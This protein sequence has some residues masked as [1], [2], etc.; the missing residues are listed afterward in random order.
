MENNDTN[1]NHGLD[2]TTPNLNKKENNM[3]TKKSKKTGAIIA[4]SIVAVIGVAGLI[5]GGVYLANKDKN[6]N[7]PTTVVSSNETT[8]TS[9]GTA[10]VDGKNKI[11]KGGTYTFTGSTSNG[12]IE[13]ETTEPVT[14]VLDN[15]SITN[16]EGEAIKCE[17]GSNVTIQLV[18]ENSLVSTDPGTAE[19]DPDNVISSDGDLTLTGDGS[20]TI[21]GNDKGIHADGKIVIESGTYNIEKATEGI[22][23]TY[24]VI[25]GGNI[26]INATDDGINASQ[27]STAYSVVFEM[28]GGNVTIV[29]GQGDTDAIDS[30]GDLYINGGTLIITAQSPFDYDGTAKYTGGTMI[31]NGEA[32]TQIT[33]QFANDGGGMM[34]GGDQGQQGGT[35]PQGQQQ[36]RR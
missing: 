30:N 10:L 35:P 4:V 14:I 22:E 20:V 12:K 18:G 11:A 25:N 13:V 3:P 5:A 31:I 6:D 24:I 1:I 34:P 7:T 36:M 17:E 28:N 15:V 29:M 19:D 26:S 32:T 23:A 8:S 33:N 21:S 27:K 16:T 2:N 9:S